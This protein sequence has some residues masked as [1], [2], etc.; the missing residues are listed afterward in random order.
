MVNCFKM[1][2]WAKIQRAMSHP[3]ATNIIDEIRKQTIPALEIGSD[4]NS[5]KANLERFLGITGATPH[6]SW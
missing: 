6:I 1:R 4:A 2:D 5:Q 3:N